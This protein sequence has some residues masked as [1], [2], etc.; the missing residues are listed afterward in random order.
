SDYTSS[1]PLRLYRFLPAE[2]KVQVITYDTTMLQVTGT[3]KYKSDR[4]SHQFSLEYRMSAAQPSR[5]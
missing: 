1:G 3:T 4:A 5:P 2:D